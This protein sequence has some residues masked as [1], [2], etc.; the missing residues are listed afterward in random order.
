MNVLVAFF[1]PQTP[2]FWG[3]VAKKFSKAP[4]NG[5]W[6]AMGNTFSPPPNPHINFYSIVSSI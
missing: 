6:E 1:S 3:S 4:T 2:I 5:G